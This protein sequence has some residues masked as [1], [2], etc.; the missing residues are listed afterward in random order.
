[1]M[2]SLSIIQW[3]GAIIYYT[4]TVKKRKIYGSPDQPKR[5]PTHQETPEKGT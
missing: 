5:A 1:M 3:D 4:S 2:I